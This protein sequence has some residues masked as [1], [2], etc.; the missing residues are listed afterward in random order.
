[1][2][3]STRTRGITLVELLVVIF[4]ISVLAGALVPVL[5]RVRA[6]TRSTY[7]VANLHQVLLGL[8]MYALDYGEVPLDG[9]GYDKEKGIE[10]IKWGAAVLP[11]VGAEDAFLCP[12]DPNNG[13]MYTPWAGI[14]CSWPYLYTIAAVEDFQGRG[15]AVASYSPL[16]GC[17]WHR[18]E[19]VFI[20]GRKD[21]S[22]EVAPT[23][24]YPGGICALFE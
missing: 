2:S 24:K 20:I 6:R 21:A 17:A 15:K 12:D 1:M 9:G 16:M 19:K 14:P 4:I 11:Y 5:W 23:W 10:G 8:Q 3:D 22:V 13:E 18:K 7:C